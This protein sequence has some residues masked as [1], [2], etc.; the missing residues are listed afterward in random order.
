M[1]EIKSF[2][3]EMVVVLQIVNILRQSL[4]EDS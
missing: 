3:V 1:M 4:W 2:C